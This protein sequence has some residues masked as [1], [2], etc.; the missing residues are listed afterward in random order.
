M[1]VYRDSKLELTKDYPLWLTNGKTPKF[2]HSENRNLPSLRKQNPDPLVEVHPKT[3]KQYGLDNGDWA[4]LE[5]VFGK[6][7]MKVK[8]TE[9]IKSNVICAQH[10]WWFPEDKDLENSWKTSN[11]N[12][13]FGYTSY[14]PE[15]GSEIMR[16]V[17][18]KIYK[19]S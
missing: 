13:L 3:A 15:I 4:N 16:G 6:I 12:M 11:V 10:G 2:F 9:T 1:P 18:C 7:R 5:T 19:E 17:P 14:D 8:T